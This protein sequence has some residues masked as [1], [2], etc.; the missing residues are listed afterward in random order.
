MISTFRTLYPYLV[1]YR[2]SYAAGGAALFVGSAFA[3]AVPLVVREAVDRFVSGASP[4]ELQ[5][6]A[7]LVVAAVFAKGVFR[8]ISRSLIAG[9][10]RRVEFDLRGDLFLR[11]ISF[12]RKFFSSYRTGDLTSR[13]VNDLT[14]IRALL[15]QGLSLMF[16][17]SLTFIFALAVMSSVDWKLTCAIFA[18]LPLITLTVSYFGHEIHSRF[19]AV[20]SRLGGLTSVV[21]QNI[22]NARLVRAY[23]SGGY[24]NNHFDQ[25][26]GL[27]YD[28]NMQL[29]GLWRRMYPTMELLIGV[30]YV[31]VLI[32]G[33]F[34]VLDGELSVGSFVMF[35]AYMAMLTWPM[36]GLGWVVNLIQRGSAALERVN[37]I[38]S[39]RAEIADGPATDT[40]IDGVR[41]DLSLSGVTY[42]H[43]G[44]DQPALDD[45]TFEVPVGQTVAIVGPVGSGKSTL[46][47]L[48]PRLIEPSSGVVRVDGEDLER[49]PLAVLRGSIG[50]ARQEPFLLNMTLG[51]NL[52]FGA[53]GPLEQ[54]QVDEAVEIAAL[55]ETVESLPQGYETRVGE[56]GVKLSGGQRQRAALVRALLREPR[57]LLLDDALS[58]VDAET[59]AS[60]IENLRRFLRNRTTLIATHRLSAARRADRVVVLEN[61]RIVEDGTHDDLVEARGRYWDLWRKQT[62]EEELE[63]DE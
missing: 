35:V 26:N 36:I 1:R 22:S 9:S 55:T 40:S 38:L 56:R 12:S 37:E 29:V 13:A 30:G 63:H 34:R 39:R 49:I 50:L 59:E 16:D 60:I 10:A 33:G 45:V 61:G 48:V 5:T 18:P 20:Q 47:D 17:L 3:A 23:S 2:W 62:L 54:W 27:Y 53:P 31:V 51:E 43:P 15:G 25:L 32:Y 21:E 8:F 42:F 7:A 24:A 14:A 6:P 28:E 41:G 58:S 46:L 57:F 52:L 44:A 11:I 4:A 19:R